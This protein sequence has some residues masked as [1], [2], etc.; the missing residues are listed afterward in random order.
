MTDTWRRKLGDRLIGSQSVKTVHN[1][2]ASLS[3]SPDNGGAGRYRW[4]RAKDK[5]GGGD[6]RG[7][8]MGL[9]THHIHLVGW[10]QYSAWL[11]FLL[12]EPKLGSQKC[13]RHAKRWLCATTCSHISSEQVQIHTPHPLMEAVASQFQHFP[14]ES[15]LLLGLVWNR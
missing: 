15:G 6:C 7:G 1:I 8:P 14:C 4:R 2:M 11:H 5:L 9:A 10:A 12:Q 13:E 3:T